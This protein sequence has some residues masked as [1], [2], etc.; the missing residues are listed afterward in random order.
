MEQVDE[1]GLVYRR[2]V[3]MSL[4]SLPIELHAAVARA[5]TAWPQVA[6]DADRFVGRLREVLGDQPVEAVAGLHVEDLYLAWACTEGNPEALAAFDARMW[7]AADATLAR[8][9]IDPARRE[10]L[11]QDLRIH[12][13]VGS[14]GRPGKLAQY[15]GQGDL[16]RWLRATTLRAAYRMVS[17]TRRYV[18]LDD[19]ALAAVS[20]LDR[21]PALVQLKEHCRVELKHAFATALAGLARRDRLLLK[22]HYL[23]QLTI[24]DVAA[25]HNI[26]RS[27]A[28]RWLA[29]AREALASAVLSEFRD[30]L[31]VADSEVEG[32]VQLVRSQLDIT[33]ERF[34]SVG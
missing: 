16:G 24:E 12:L 13:V 7:P 25:L 20:V 17:K 23:D 3:S 9:R 26:H 30:R 15:R 6:A 27:S 31:R 11:I 1:R 22:Q 10:D 29:Q 19:T 32:L 2:G 4:D 18:T 8:L 21:D 28:A 33:L 14:D 34:L 5:R